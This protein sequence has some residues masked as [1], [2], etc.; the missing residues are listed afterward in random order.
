MTADHGSTTTFEALAGLI[1]ETLSLGDIAIRPDQLLFYD[2]E[3]T[4][5]D[6][7]DLLFR[8]EENLG[9]KVAE[10]TIYQLARGDLADARFADKGYLTGEGRARLMALL[11]DTPENVFPERIHVQ[12]LP[13]YCTV[14]ALARLLDHLRGNQGGNQGEPVVG[15]TSG[16]PT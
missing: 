4:S 11:A 2:L 12:T 10:G 14:G 7:L 8:I 6:L 5:L 16:Q 9:I 15:Q 1:R 3:F 13:R